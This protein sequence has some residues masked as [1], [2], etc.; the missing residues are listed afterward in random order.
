MEFRDAV[1]QV[2]ECPTRQQIADAIG[3]SIHSVVQAMLPEDSQ[4][5]RPA[6]AGWQSAVA[7]LARQRAA[8]LVKLAGQLE[9]P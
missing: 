9:K 6:P 3:V 8:E 5:R 4:G 7:G 1:D 2:R